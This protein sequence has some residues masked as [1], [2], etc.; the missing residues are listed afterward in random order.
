MN[1]MHEGAVMEGHDKVRQRLDAWF[2]GEV[3]QGRELLA[4]REHLS[5]CQ[6][7]A[8]Y[9]DEL[10]VLDRALYGQEE[11]ADLPD[12]FER[13]FGEA[14][15]T[16]V[17]ARQADPAMG[18]RAWW[19]AAQAWLQAV[20]WS[21]WAGASA[22]L[23]TIALVATWAWWPSVGAVDDGGAMQARSAVTAEAGL[24]R[25][26]AFCARRSAT[27]VQFVA[28]DEGGVLRCRPGDALKFALLN[29]PT[30]RAEALPYVSFVGRAEAGEPVVLLPADAAGP[31]SASMAAPATERL[32][33]FGETLRLEAIRP[34]GSLGIVAVFSAVPLDAA[35]L[36]ARVASNP[37]ADG[38]TLDLDGLSARGPEGEVVVLGRAGAGRWVATRPQRVEIEA[39]LAGSEAP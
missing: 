8:R 21:S 33:P 32:T 35:A 10:A 16:T 24:H 23:A 37:A 30:A 36:K 4:V 22:L 12:L 29:A 2:V 5:R 38:A 34:S 19:A 17:V 3:E 13:R 39:G 26:E 28:A 9:F 1:G 20:E 14:V 7:C 15:L 31:G 6:M 25:F 27:K 11:A 18:P